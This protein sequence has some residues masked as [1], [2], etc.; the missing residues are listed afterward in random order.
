[1]YDIN[2]MKIL[3]EWILKSLILLITSYI[4]P[5]FQIESYT[6]AFLVAFVLGVLNL[7]V[8]PVL[9]IL[10]LPINILTLGLFTFVVNAI[11]L[12]I[13][14]SLVKGFHIDSFFTAIVASVFISII[15]GL[16][17]KVF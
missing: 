8:K 3:A 7:L 14:S 13:A 16:L 12:L 4:V 2:T 11:L 15:S 5:G 6:T 1:M 10:T 17:S 9:I